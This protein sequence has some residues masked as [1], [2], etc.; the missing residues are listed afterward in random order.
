MTDVDRL[1]RFFAEIVREARAN[2]AFAARLLDTLRDGKTVSRGPR[3]VR[4]ARGPFDPFELHGTQGEAALRKRLGD[5]T[6]EQLKDIVAEHG[7]DQARLAMK[8]KTTGRLVDLIAT[9]VATRSRKG[10][11]FRAG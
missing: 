10:D 5:L 11:A 4:R 1:A 7:M 9:T 6:V 3:Q 8:W 2:P